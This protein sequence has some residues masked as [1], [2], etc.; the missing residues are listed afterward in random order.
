MSAISLAAYG[1]ETIPPTSTIFR[2]DNAPAIGITEKGFLWAAL[3]HDLA[4]RFHLDALENALFRVRIALREGERLGLTVHIEDHKAATA[5]GERTSHKHLS[6]LDQRLNV[7]EMS[8]PNRWAERSAIR[9]IVT[10]DYEEHFL[11]TPQLS[12]PPT[13]A[14]HPAASP[15]NY[16]TAIAP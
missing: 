15:A 5:V 1:A 13:L 16:W 6:T 14:R 7:V 2:L 4:K 3:W 10:D 8:G 11:N 9:R 12:M